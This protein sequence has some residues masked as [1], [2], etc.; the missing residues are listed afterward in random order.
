MSVRY[1]YLN[2]KKLPETG[3]GFLLQCVVRA[4]CEHCR[5]SRLILHPLQ[6]QY[7]CVKLAAEKALKHQ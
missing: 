1:S 3:S 4:V 7:D 5:G 6:H 2:S